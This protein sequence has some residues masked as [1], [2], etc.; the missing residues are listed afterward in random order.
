M[1]QSKNKEL[2]LANDPVSID[3]KND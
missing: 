1:Q 3:K 2:K